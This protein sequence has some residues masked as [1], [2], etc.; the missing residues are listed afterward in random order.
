MLRIEYFM[1]VGPPSPA[2]STMHCNV[3]FCFEKPNKNLAEKYL[4]GSWKIVIGWFGVT[5]IHIEGAK[6]FKGI[7]GLICIKKLSFE[8]KCVSFHFFCPN[9]SPP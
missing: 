5:K 1:H 7:T 4:E 8:K 3:T 6:A 9:A 2:P